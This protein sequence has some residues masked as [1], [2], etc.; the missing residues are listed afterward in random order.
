MTDSGASAL[1]GGAVAYSLQHF[2]V[3]LHTLAV[4]FV[5]AGAFQ[6]WSSVTVSRFRAA[7]QVLSG[8]II[9]AVGAH[10]LIDFVGIQSVPITMISAA[11]FAWACAPIFE[12]LTRNS[13]KVI[14]GAADKIGGKNE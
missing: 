11:F 6:A 2:G 13:G 3:D 9:G 7:A 5:G 1:L 12:H 10:A 14:D 8:A 4:A